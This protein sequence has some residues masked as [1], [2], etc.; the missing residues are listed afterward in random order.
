MKKPIP[1][2]LRT[3]VLS[4]IFAFTGIINVQAQTL[5]QEFI[6]A[7][8]TLVDLGNISDV[9]ANY[10]G[11][12]IRVEEPNN[13]YIGGAAN[14]TG[15]AVYSVPLLRDSITNSIIGFAGP[16][17]RFIDAPNIDGGLVFTPEGTMLF[18][19]YSMNELG[20]ILP[21]ESYV[22]VPL[23]PLGVSSSVGS[24]AFVPEGFPGAGNLIFSSYSS[25][26]MHRVP[27]TVEASGFYTLSAATDEVLVT[28]TASGPEGIAYVPLGSAGFTNPSM[29]VSAYSLG[30]VVVMEVDTNGLP[31][32]ATAREMVTALSGAEGAWIDPVTGDFLFSTFGGFNR[33]IRVSGFERPTAIAESSQPSQALIVAPNPTNGLLRI[34]LADNQKIESVKVI[35]I[36]GRVVK[37][38]AHLVD[39]MIDLG[40]LPTGMYTLLVFSGKDVRAARV[41]RE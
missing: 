40:A 14:Q 39:G 23:S 30:K 8:Y 24:L 35:D 20:Q 37:Q 13:L 29:I 1:F 3:I 18:T 36:Q 2:A 5:T 4:G 34:G 28:S 33:V 12:T 41:L 6:D 26:K 21:D 19:R 7:G 16:A 10:G 11:L 27:Y 17:Q 32:N 25:S 38:I 22:S 31:I 15:A 9:P